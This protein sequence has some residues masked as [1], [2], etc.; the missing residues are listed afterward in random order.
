MRSAVVYYPRMGNTKAFAE[1]L[2]KG[3]GCEV[4]PFNL[5]EIT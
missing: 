2:A 5:M 1:L 4:Y 3:L